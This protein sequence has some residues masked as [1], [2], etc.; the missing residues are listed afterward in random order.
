MSMSLTLETFNI[1]NTFRLSSDL[2]LAPVGTSTLAF[3]G[4][5]L[6]G[7]KDPSWTVPS[8]LRFSF[9]DDEEPELNAGQTCPFLS[10]LST[11]VAM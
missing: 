8:F 5:V 4:S 7:T 10:C 6:E 9:Q 2:P 3:G 1:T 11:L